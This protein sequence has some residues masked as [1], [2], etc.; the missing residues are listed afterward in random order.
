MSARPARS[1]TRMRVRRRLLERLVA[2]HRGDAE[3]LELRAREREQQ[4]DRV[5]VPGI[6]VEDDRDGHA[7][8]IG[9]AGRACPSISRHRASLGPASTVGERDVQ[10]RSEHQPR[11]QPPERRA[12]PAEGRAGRRHEERHD[13]SVA[14]ARPPGR[15]LGDRHRQGRPERAEQRRGPRPTR[16]ALPGRR[17]R[18]P[19]GALPRA[20]R[21][22]T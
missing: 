10:D 1:S 2:V 21:R 8:S 11:E 7:G 6:A 3:Q 22:C 20:R 16:R 15:I 13:R 18:A 9:F 19:T 17:R 5:V 4:R 12:D 14:I